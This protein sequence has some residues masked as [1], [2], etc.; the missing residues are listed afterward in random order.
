M[1][2]VLL[3]I[4]DYIPDSTK[5]AA[6]MMH[7]LACELIERGNRVT[8]VTPSVAIEKMI[9]KEFVDGVEIIRFRL[10][11]IKNCG[12][13]KRAI[14]ETILPFN[15]SKF[16][17]RTL[18]ERHYDLIV[19]YSPSIFWGRFALQLKKKF[20]C[21]CYL[22]LRDFFP[23]WVIDNG[24]IKSS[25][26]VAKY[27]RYIERLNY[28]SA[29][30][31]GI[32][33][34]ANIKFFKQC[35]G[36]EYQ[37]RLLYNWASP[38]IGNETVSFKKKLGIED[39][40][41]FFYGGN[42]GKAQDMANLVRLAQRLQNKPQA[43][44]VFLGNGDEVDLVKEMIIKNNVSNL[45][46]LPSVSQKEFKS[47]LKEVDVG[48]FSLSRDHESHN[49]PGKILGYMVNKIPILGSV[50]MGNDLQAII[51]EYDAGL[52]TVNGEDDLLVKNALSLLENPALRR[53]SGMNAG[54][55]LHARFTV[56][57]AADEILSIL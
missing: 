2:N 4:D 10:G 52:V 24:M 55:L 13:I 38:N 3:L 57:S 44:F 1:K 53:Q 31:I 33:S 5:V 14:N 46:L 29:D 27:F 51:S 37:T 9:M 23:Q 28:Q 47:I 39:K 34:L 50:N 41:L 16:T 43:H 32:Q 48:L 8:V 26:L 42:I 54:R 45:T 56:A 21:P 22:I 20:S 25:S 19:N 36:D 12:F 15:A 40:I 49:F 35:F 17:M 6:K 18:S 30:A 11:K 7:E